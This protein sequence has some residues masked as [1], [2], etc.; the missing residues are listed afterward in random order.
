MFQFVFY[1]GG[2]LTFEDLLAEVGKSREEELDDL[3]VV[4]DL[5]SVY[6]DQRG[7]HLTL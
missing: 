2:F 1:I 6:F 4:V 5:L 3:Q 7:F